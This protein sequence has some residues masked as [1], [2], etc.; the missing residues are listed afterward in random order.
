MLK[1]LIVGVEEENRRK[2]WLCQEKAVPLRPHL[3]M[4]RPVMTAVRHPKDV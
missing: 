1:R 2:V 3:K 4:R